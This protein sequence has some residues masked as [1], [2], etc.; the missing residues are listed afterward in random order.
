MNDPAKE[1]CDGRLW[2]ELCETLK[3]AGEAVQASSPDTG[4]DRAEGY[5]YLARITRHALANF[6]ET[7][8]V[9]APSFNY[10]S[11]KIG[12]DNPDFLYGRAVVSSQFRYRLS[13]KLNQVANLG[14]GAYAGGLGSAGGL[15]CE[16]YLGLA[17]LGADAAGCFELIASADPGD[18]PGLRL[19]CE[20]NSLLIRQTVLDRRHHQPAEIA[21]ERIGGERSE[22]RPLEAVGFAAQLQA[23]NR[24]VGG[25]V[26]QFLTWTR[27]FAARA[28][29]IHPLPPELLGLAQGDPN[30]RYYNGY[31]EL[32]EDEGLLVELAPPACEY[33]NIQAANHWL[34]SLDFERHNTVIN[35]SNAVP[36][37]DGRVRIIF[38]QRDPNAPNWIDTAGHGRGGIA[39]RWIG[40]ETEPPA[41]KTRLIK[42][43]PKETMP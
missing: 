18:A 34:E 26:S 17:E 11:P 5:R 35:N 37:E 42:L 6:L 41:P 2:Q 1:L 31:F 4:L 33:W 12:C 29:E 21:I 3:T 25:V 40:A 20:T 27:T 32:G 8:D 39:L 22:P 14:I 7:H 16:A 19:S 23:S 9:A 10:D 43:S 13:G 28:N 36:A 30:T 38:A 24:F 15:K